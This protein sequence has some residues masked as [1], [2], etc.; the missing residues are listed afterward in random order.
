MITKIH[1]ILILIITIINIMINKLVMEEFPSMVDNLLKI[2]V[3]KI[4][5]K[6]LN[7]TII[8]TTS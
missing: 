2:Q 5:N 8:R 1:L 4:Y 6:L 7:K 3:N